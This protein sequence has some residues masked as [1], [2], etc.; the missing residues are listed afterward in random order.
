GSMRLR[1]FPVPRDPVAAAPDRVGRRPTGD[2][3][4][5]QVASDVEHLPQREPG[6]Q[7]WNAVPGQARQRA[8]EHAKERQ[9]SG[10]LPGEAAASSPPAR[11]MVPEGAAAIVEMLKAE[12]REVEVTGMGDHGG[13]CEAD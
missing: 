5:V 1:S 10:G 7:G 2:R 12:S 13:G 11:T 6:G 8:A 9:V 3:R 4:L